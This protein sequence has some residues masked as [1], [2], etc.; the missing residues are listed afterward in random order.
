MYRAISTLGT[1]LDSI[2]G[3]AVVTKDGESYRIE[4]EFTELMATSRDYGELT[5]AWKAWRDATG[6]QM[7]EKYS[8]L[9][10][11]MNQ[12][13]RDNGQFIYYRNH[14]NKVIIS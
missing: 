10:D 2:Y 1:E 6:P 4:P 7:K 8:Q 3:N 9:V 14:I 13:A 11:N 5:W 12:A